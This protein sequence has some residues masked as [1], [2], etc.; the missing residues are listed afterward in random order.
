[1]SV[2][3]ENV[4]STAGQN[5]LSVAGPTSVQGNGVPADLEPHLRRLGLVDSVQ[6]VLGAVRQVYCDAERVELSIFRDEYGEECVRVKAIVPEE[7]DEEAEMYFRCL[8][9][10]TS[11][12]A[13]NAD[14]KIIFTTS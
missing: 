2:N 5:P 4:Q 12:I 3:T 14:G 1:M 11:A 7:G 9:L 13:P 6:I 8:S 10:W